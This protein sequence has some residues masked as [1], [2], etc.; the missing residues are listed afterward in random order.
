[1]RKPINDFKYKGA[2]A[3]LVSFMLSV[4]FTQAGE[5]ESEIKTPPFGVHN[6]WPVYNYTQYLYTQ[7]YDIHILGTQD[8]SEWMMRESQNLVEKMVG[9]LR[10]PADRKKFAAHRNF[11]V[12]DND[13]SIPGNPKG[14]RNTGGN[15]FSM[16]NE[17][18]VCATAVDTL[19]PE[20]QPVKRGWDTP[21]HEFAHAIEFTLGLGKRSD[22]VYKKHVKNYDPKVAREYFTWSV[23]RWFDS[24]GPKQTRDTM[25]KWE[26][27]FIATV[28]DAQN[29]WKPKCTRK[30][31][32]YSPRKDDVKTAVE[33]DRPA[34]VAIGWDDIEAVAGEYSQAV[35]ANNWHLGEISVMKRDKKGRPVMLKWTNKAGRSWMLQPDLKTAALHTGPDN[36]YHHSPQGKA[37]YIAFD[38]TNP[39]EPRVAGFWFQGTLFFKKGER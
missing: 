39:G 30:G 27:N 15:G 35:P 19:Y 29:T 1:M 37:F 32:V 4:N 31:K 17:M 33:D 5:K 10:R 7:K 14:H 36:P 9:A 2:I 18:L 34:P 23:Q 13:P 25:P 28:F 6:R 20:G 26:Y 11:L 38:R 16:F 12:T 24:C 21:V 8:V 22:E 3:L